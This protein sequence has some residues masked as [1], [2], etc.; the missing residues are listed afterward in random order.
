MSGIGQYVLKLWYFSKVESQA[1]AGDT[2]KII[3]RDQY[4]LPKLV[5]KLCYH[6]VLFCSPVGYVLRIV[7]VG[8]V[9]QSIRMGC[10]EP[11][12]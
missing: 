9:K 4:L 1:L 7:E 11:I 10:T 5:W 2:L 3:L 6:Y 8:V 12:N